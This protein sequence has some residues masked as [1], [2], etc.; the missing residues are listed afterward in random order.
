MG[1]QLLCTD[2]ECFGIIHWGECPDCGHREY[3]HQMGLCGECEYNGPDWTPLEDTPEMRLRALGK[4]WEAEQVEAQKCADAYEANNGRLPA[5]FL[6]GQ[7]QRR[8]PLTNSQEQ[9]IVS[10]E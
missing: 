1:T 3:F 2:P 4:N 8:Q 9:S 5:R 6:A 7:G 10:K